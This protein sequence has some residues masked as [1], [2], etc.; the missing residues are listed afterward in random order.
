MHAWLF[1]GQGS[2]RPGMGADVLKRFPDHVAAADEILGLAVGELCLHDSGGLLR[3]TRHV[4]PALFVVEALTALAARE[5]G[6]PPPGVLAGH[7][8][9]EYAALFTAG[10]FDFETGVRLTRHRGE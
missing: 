2:H 6:A 9:G 5:D 8:L 1:P 7:S 3:D 4:Q 10:C